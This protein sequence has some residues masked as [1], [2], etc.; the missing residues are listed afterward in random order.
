MGCLGEPWREPRAN[1]GQ[2]DRYPLPW[3]EH[4]FN[5][6][7][8]MPPLFRAVFRTPT[9]CIWLGVLGSGAVNDVKIKAVQL[10]SPPGLPPVKW[11]ILGEPL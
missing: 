10:K 7:V 3:F 4:V 8:V 2:H 9:Q 1:R 5:R 6:L 11:F